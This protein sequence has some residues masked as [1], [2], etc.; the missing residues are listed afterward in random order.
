MPK[1]VVL[2]RFKPKLR[3]LW[4]LTASLAAL[5]SGCEDPRRSRGLFPI[6]GIFMQ[7]GCSVYVTKF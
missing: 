6:K 2:T 7:L 1:T 5:S 4:L 3:S